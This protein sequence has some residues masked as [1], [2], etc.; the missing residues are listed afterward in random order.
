M[1][2]SWSGTTTALSLSRLM[3]LDKLSIF[4]ECIN[5][6]IQYFFLFVFDIIFSFGNKY[7]VLLVFTKSRLNE[8]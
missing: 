7:K 4:S 2:W 1:A 8:Y 5:D 6:L 3:Y